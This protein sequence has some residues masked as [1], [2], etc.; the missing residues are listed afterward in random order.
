MELPEEYTFETALADLIDNSLQ[1]VWA[2]DESDGRLIS[3]E[4]SNEKISIFDTGPGMDSTSI[5]KWG[6]MGASPHR[7]Y[8]AQAI[9]GK[10]PY[11]KPAFGMFGYGG[12][13][14]SMHL[15][16]CTEV[17]S[18]TKHGKKVYMLRLERDALVSGSVSGSK[19][20]WRTYGRLRDPTNDELELSPGGS[21]TK[22]EIFEPKIR[23]TNNIRW[24]QFKLKDIYFSYI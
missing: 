23:S 19:A 4:V 21:F 3:V 1:A 7:A 16:R 12:F 18:K 2:N 6:K 11:L 8:K 22:V 20:T 5:E 17:L 13:I 15:G 9:G 14:A 10:P 24:L